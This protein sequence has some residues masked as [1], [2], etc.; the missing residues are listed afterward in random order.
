MEIKSENTFQPFVK[1]NDRANGIHRC[2]RLATQ[3]PGKGR[4]AAVKPFQV[5]TR[6]CV[7]RA[8]LWLPISMIFVWPSVSPA[9]S[10]SG[11]TEPAVLQTEP[12]PNVLRL[13]DLLRALRTRNPAVLSAKAEW[14]AARK[15]VWID[16]ALPDPMA[17][18]DLMGS[19]RE[20]RVGPETSRYMVSQDVPFPIK[21]I[22]KGR[23]ARKEA[24]AA[25]AR[26]RAVEQDQAEELTKFYYKLY[27]LDASIEVIEEVKAIL[28]KFEAASEARYANRTSGQRDVAKAQA[29]VSM[30]LEK[31][32]MLQQERQSTAS[33]IQALIDQDP[34]LPIGKVERPAIPGL[35]M[36]LVD[37]LNLA[38]E[39]R[40]EVK[41]REALVAKSE[42]AK[43]LAKLSFVPD[44]TVGFEYTGVGAGTTDMGPDMD[45]RDSWMIPLRINLPLWGQ[46]IVPEIQEAQKMIEAN[47]AKL[48][49]A[50]NTTFYE[51]K[52]AFY[53]FDTAS[54]L[55]E[56]YETSILPQAEL[57]L[58]A[59]QA[60]YESGNAG[61]LELLDSERVYLNAKLSHIRLLTEALQSYAE[62]RRA[63]GLDLEKETPKEASA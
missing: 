21:L 4:P 12:A 56:L 30:S 1:Q 31:L 10:E 45:G 50:K 57:A 11:R 52:D 51:V 19:M 2:T 60:G 15:R 55:V 58:R 22:E 40:Q 26:F 24:E 39:N 16:T 53:R 17:G 33:M 61:F 23:M 32:F 46:R 8:L 37:L 34:L 7:S 44:L 41:E 18:Y 59:D 48:A 35:Q 29:E 25:Y 3:A 6:P 5:L 38:V 36:T 20:T 27:A 54:K 43:K 13:D 62:L 47:Q 49:E 63:A 28:K 9:Q 42:H 14:L